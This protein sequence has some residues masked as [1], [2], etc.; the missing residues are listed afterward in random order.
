MIKDNIKNA[1]KYY[2]LSE[3]IEIALKY[4]ETTNFSE[5]QDGSYEIKGREIYANVQ[6]YL[7]K[8]LSS[9]KFEAHKKYIDIQFVVEGEER[10][11]IFDISN[12]DV[13]I[14]YS[15]QK[16]IE[17]LKLKNNDLKYSFVTLKQNEFVILPPT[18]AHMPSVSS[19]SES[20]VKKVVVKLLA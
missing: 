1:N 17:F 18:D 3:R 4:L 19:V 13:D 8:S 7:T 20:T 16:D 9:A 6:T 11:G 10:I 14:P 12:F 15:T 2:P 5:L